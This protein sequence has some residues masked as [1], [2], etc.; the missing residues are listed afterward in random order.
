MALQRTALAMGLFFGLVGVS[1]QAEAARPDSHQ[2]PA[3]SASRLA[4]PARAAARPAN[5]L[6]LVSMSEAP[7]ASRASV[8]PPV[9]PGP[10]GR[11]LAAASNG[12]ISCVPYARQATGMSIS[13]NGWQWWGNAAGSYAR[14]SRPEPGSVLAFR[15]S[16][17]MQHGHVAVVSR[18][19]SPRQLLIDHANWA[20]PGI[21]RGTV[22]HDVAVIDVS[23]DNDW[24][25]VRVQVGHDASSFGRSYPAY[26]FIHNRP[27][28][29]RWMAQSELR[30]PGFE[31]VAEAFEPNHGPVA[32]QRGSGNRWS[33]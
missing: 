20:G 19:L 32:G 26:G 8:R 5:P 28:G 27:D 1:S 9:R 16:G 21:R 15:S 17:H 33:R 3:I 7:A 11:R 22:M 30:E 25:D 2:A 23:P 24:T 29:N 13:G 14:G 31:E 12:G 6:R 10:P 4:A 18:Q